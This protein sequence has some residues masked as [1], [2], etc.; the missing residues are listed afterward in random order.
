MYSYLRDTRLDC[1][2]A[3]R[4]STSK[5]K[6]RLGRCATWIKADTS[7]LGLKFALREFKDRVFIGDKPE[8]MSRVK[9]NGSLYIDKLSI[10]KKPGSTLQETWF[11]NLVEFNHGLIAIIGNRGSGKSALSETIGLIGNTQ[12]FNDFSF[13]NE[14]KFRKKSENKAKEFIASLTWANG[15]KIDRFLSDPIDPVSPELVQ[16]IPQNFLEHICNEVPVGEDNDFSKELKRVIFSHIDSADRL[17]QCDLDSLIDSVTGST[18]GAIKLIQSE[19]SAINAEIIDYENQSIESFKLNLK[20]QLS[21][22]WQQLNDLMDARPELIEPVSDAPQMQELTA[23]ITSISEQIAETEA[24]IEEKTSELTTL[25]IQTNQLDRFEENALTLERSFKNLRTQYEPIL[26]E[27]GLKFDDVAKLIIMKT[28]VKFKKEEVSGRV[29]ILSRELD[30][31]IQESLPGIIVQL[32]YAKGS[33]QEKLDEPQQ[34]YQKSL[35]ELE[36]WSQRRKTIIGDSNTPDTIVFIRSKIQDLRSIP[37][38][39]Q[40]AKENRRSKS[41]EIYRLLQKL[42]LEYQRFYRGVQDFIDKQITAQAIKLILSSMLVQN[43]FGETFLENFNRHRSSSFAPVAKG[44]KLVGDAIAECDFHS[45]VSVLNYIEKIDEY[46]HFDFNYDPPSLVDIDSLMKK[47]KSRLDVYNY[48]F[49][50]SY[51]TP[52]YMLKFGSKQLHELSPGEKGTILLIFYLLVDKTDTP[53]VIDQ[54]EDNL[55]NQ[56]VAR[57]LVDCIKQTKRRR[58]IFIVTHN[59]NL[60]VVCDAEQIIS[61]TIDK[62]KGNEVSYSCGAIENPKINPSV[63]DILEGTKPAFDIRGGKYF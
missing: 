28:L 5:D 49:G 56:T 34:L 43:N 22:K 51:V 6:D 9:T 32:Q 18:Q 38:K 26:S 40:Q 7:F 58:Q 23:A 25:N 14:L 2:D 62:E 37:Q 45:E 3:H 16:F 39:L 36:E 44:D 10:K 13:L 21:I 55:D 53:L 8:I 31:S 48:L 57:I 52:V 54:P 60:A 1:S 50:L 63:V 30:A 19:I 47:G 61:C 46:M 11:D 29:R 12:H 15:K 24:E 33:L 17:G 27:V 59:P 41:Q 4:F 42:V 20:K 35:T